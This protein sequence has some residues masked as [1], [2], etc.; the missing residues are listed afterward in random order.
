MDITSLVCSIL[1][2][3]IFKMSRKKE[4]DKSNNGHFWHETNKTSFDSKEE[5]IIAL[6]I[7]QPT[8]SHS[9]TSELV[10]PKCI[11]AVTNKNPVTPSPSVARMPKDANDCHSDLEDDSSRYRGHAKRY[12]D[13]RKSDTCDVII[14]N[15]NEK[16]KFDMSVK[17]NQ[18]EKSLQ[19][20]GYQMEYDKIT[21]CFVNRLSFFL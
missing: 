7:T 13:S 19:K 14:R 17:K 16:L 11:N 20:D 5:I 9:R 4:T 12:S 3:F 6:G 2:I 10:T 18:R 1:V 15:T 21:T 8:N